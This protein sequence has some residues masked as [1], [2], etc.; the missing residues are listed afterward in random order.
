MNRQEITDR[1]DS[2]TVWKNGDRRAPHKPLLVLL[3]L[4]YLQNEDRRLLPY[5]EVEKKLE[6]LLT[7]FGTIRN[8]SNTHYPFWRLQNERIWEIERSDELLVNSSGDVRKTELRQKNIRAGF[9]EEVYNLLKKNPELVAE[10]GWKIL[11]AHFPETIHEDIIHET[12]F[13][14]E[15]QSLSKQRDPNFRREVLR[16]Y[17]HRCAV[18]DFDVRI[19][20]KTLCIEA[21][22]IKWHSAGGPDDISNGIALCTMHHKLFD[23]GAF[24]L[25][26][27][28]Q[29]LVSERVTGNN[30]FDLWLARYH[31]NVITKPI[32]AVYEPSVEYIAWNRSE[33][34]KMP[35]R[36]L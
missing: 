31:G 28:R 14:P 15:G 19:G 13:S 7:E 9:T 18:C 24:T 36:E 12:G 10:V 26:K 21:A 33:V 25:D 20:A 11:Q 30:G 23:L 8:A 34:F 1:F 35:E 4:G 2:L 22:H 16:A 17:E 27:N 32:R 6:A 29:F 5:P 3:A